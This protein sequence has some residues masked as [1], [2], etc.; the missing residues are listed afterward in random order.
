MKADFTFGQPT[1]TGPTVNSSVGDGSPSLTYDGL[2]MFF[3]SERPGGSGYWDI[4]VTSRETT[5]DDWSNAVNLGPTINTSVF[6]GM[7]NISADGLSLIFISGRSGSNL[8]DIW[9][10]TRVTRADPWGSP[11][12]LGPPVNS[13]YYEWSP[14]MTD[15]GLSLFFCS[16]RPG[17]SGVQDVWVSTRASTTDPWGE[18]VNLGPT[19]NSPA[20]EAYV[21]IS[22]DGLWMFLSEYSLFRAGGIGS[23]DLWLS[24]RAA[25]ADAWGRP[26][27][28]GPPINTEFWDVTADIS[29]NCS[30]IYFASN[31]PGGVGSMDIYQV[32]IEPIVDFNGDGIVDAADM[33]IVVDHWGDN[34]SL[35]DIGPTPLGDG[36]VDVQDLI[37]LSEHLFEQVNDPTL[38]AH[39]AMDETEGMFAADSAGVNDAFIVGGAAWQPGGGQVD[40]A[41]ELDGVSGCA[42]ANFVL[43]PADSPFSIFAWIKGGGPGQVVVS[44]QNAANW[45]LTDADG[46]LITEL[47]GSNRS[48]GPLLS[49]TVITD[50][51]WHRIGFVFDGL[52]RILYVDGIIAAEDT[53]P[54]LISSQMGLYIGTG[55]AMDPE[56]CFSGLI[57]DVRIYKRAVAP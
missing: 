50:G 46:N 38:V 52:N 18:P 33:Y 12:N 26:V 37:V 25:N 45:L 41:L 8:W 29:T 55:M 14:S 4:W 22:A 16:E 15:D 21:D 9:I 2:E 54:G 23:G 6:D 11:V 32:P 53:Q 42:I 31:R 47:R 39:W 44:Q 57:D 27:N 5:E 35:C 30:T 48:S 28:L 20:G 43:D 19:V 51:Q 40:G 49:Q 3:D 34:Y 10:T 17:G 7:P 24:V 13:A 56:T 1:N 36:V